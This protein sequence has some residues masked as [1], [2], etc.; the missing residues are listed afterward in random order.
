MGVAGHLYRNI[1]VA[2][3]EDGLVD[4]KQ[5]ADLQTGDWDKKVICVFGG[6][7]SVGNGFG[8]W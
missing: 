7:R 8:G 2:G 4:S 1:C 5:I 3:L 6:E